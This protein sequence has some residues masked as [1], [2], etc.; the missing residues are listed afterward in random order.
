VH[1]FYLHLCGLVA[2]EDWFRLM[3]VSWIPSSIHERPFFSCVLS[4]QPPIAH[5]S[6]R[7]KV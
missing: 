7:G 6:C 4:L 3:F 1:L 2:G 5:F